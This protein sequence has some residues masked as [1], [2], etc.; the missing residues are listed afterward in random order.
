MKAWVVKKNATTADYHD[1]VDHKIFFKWFKQLCSLISTPSTL[2]MDN[3][4]Y[5][6]VHNVSD[7]EK[8]IFKGRTF[9]KL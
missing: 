1:N 9:S 5:H 6:K 4:G 8:E 3:A 7:W 2:I